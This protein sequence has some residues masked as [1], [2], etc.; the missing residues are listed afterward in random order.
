MFSSNFLLSSY[1]LLSPFSFFSVKIYNCSDTENAHN[2][3][4]PTANL[5]FVRHLY[6]QNVLFSSALHFL[7]LTLCLALFSC[8]DESNLRMNSVDHI[9]QTLASHMRLPGD[10]QPRGLESGSV[11]RH[12]ADMLKPDPRDTFYS[13][14]STS[15]HYGL[16]RFFCP[17]PGFQLPNWMSSS[18]SSLP[19]T[20]AFFEICHFLW[21]AVFHYLIIL[22]LPDSHICWN[23]ISKY[24]FVCTWTQ[25]F[26]S[27]SL[28]LLSPYDSPLSTGKCSSGLPLLSNL[29]RQRFSHCKI[30]RPAVC[31]S[32][33]YHL[34]S[35]LEKNLP[36]RRCDDVFVCAFKL[37]WVLR[38]VQVIGCNPVRK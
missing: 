8:K 14:K 28:I 36:L 37:D 21:L 23:Q 10:V 15:H 22:Q 20:S 2:V 30:P 32:L 16:S 11:V 7:F 38:C 34:P 18:R 3:F 27:P 33:L 4:L 17:H 24:I 5:K 31:K 35:G 19:V 25:I 1:F 12:G 29:C 9:P 13:S 26:T 6:T